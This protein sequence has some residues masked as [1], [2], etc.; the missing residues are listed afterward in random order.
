MRPLRPILKPKEVW[1]AGG[2]V[3]D[4]LLG[5]PLHDWDFT[6]AGPARALARQAANLLGGAYVTLDAERDTG[7]AVVTQPYTR[8]P[9]TLD[10]A[11]L[12]G[13]SIE[14]DLRARD[15]TLNAM[16]LDLDTGRLIDPTGG[17]KDLE[18]GFIRTTGAQSFTDDPARLLRALRVAAELDFTL[19]QS[20]RHAI[21][22][23]APRLADVAAERIT[24]ELNRILQAEPSAWGLHRAWQLGLLEIVLP[25]VA[26]L[27]DVEQSSPHHYAKAWR[28]TLAAVTA[29]E[30]LL[31][32]VQGQAL[33]TR[34][35]ITL[36]FPSWAWEMLSEALLPLQQPLLAYLAEPVSVEMDR[37]LLIKWG[38]LLHDVGKTETR[39][40]DDAGL[41]HFYGHPTTGAR[42]IQER[43][44]TLRFPTKAHHFVATLVA[45]HMRPL[46]LART[47]PPSRRALYRFFRATGDAGPGVALLF[48]SDALA[49]WGPSLE[50]GR[51]RRY[52][53]TVTTLLETYFERQAEV[54][55]PSPL[56]DGHALMALSVPQ[57]PRI[58]QLLDALREAQAAGEVTTEEEARVFI[59]EQQAQASNAGANAE[60]HEA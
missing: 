6:V 41:T 11:T 60:A 29:Y 48:L 49:V 4:L 32:R 39:T 16:A 19:E 31:A 9:I 36:P 43:L 45:Q 24:P 20:T 3:R 53:A 25:E 18:R 2:A 7:R 40:V 47:P 46:D 14:E 5:R 22:A 59:A 28:H 54:V 15:F 50:E 58:G 51:W 37:Q 21:R 55:A 27:E 34:G 26:A 12:R 38:V 35:K 42:H 23:H 10:F 33:R 30:G 52:C 8:R 44:T 13:D 56:L 57:G 1:L 17:Q